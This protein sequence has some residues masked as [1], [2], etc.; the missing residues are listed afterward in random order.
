[1]RFATDRIGLPPLRAD[2]SWLDAYLAGEA[3][4]LGS[5]IP[6]FD[7]D[8]FLNERSRLMSG[9]LTQRFYCATGRPGSGKSQAILRLLAEFDALGEATVVLSPTGKAAL[10]LNQERAEGATWE[11]Q[12]IDRWIWRSA[13]RLMRATRPIS[14]LWPALTGLNRSTISSSRKPRWSIC[15][16]SRSSFARLKCISPP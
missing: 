14:Q 15:S 7:A 2:T 1:M 8:G 5:I 6:A 13:C 3:K 4:A 10:R 12:T 11:A 16:N 9:A